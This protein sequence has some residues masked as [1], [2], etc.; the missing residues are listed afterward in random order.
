VVITFTI[1]EHVAWQIRDLAEE[2]DITWACFAPA[3]VTKLNEL[4][5]S[6]V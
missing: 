1:A 3:L 2:E 5:L 6:I 4:Y